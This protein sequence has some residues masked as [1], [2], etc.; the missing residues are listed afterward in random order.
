MNEALKMLCNLYEKPVLIIEKDRV[1]KN[2]NSNNIKYEK[3]LFPTLLTPGDILIPVQCY[4]KSS[5]P[6]ISL[7]PRPRNEI[8]FQSTFRVKGNLM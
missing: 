3:I 2:N 8:Y 6:E 5:L 1:K 4:L 7:S